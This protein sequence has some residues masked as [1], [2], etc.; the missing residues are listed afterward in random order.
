MR[1]A[2]T[3]QSP[4]WIAPSTP[5]LC[6]A[7]GVAWPG[8]WRRLWPGS[9]HLASPTHILQPLALAQP[10]VPRLLPD[11]CLL[12][13]RNP[14]GTDPDLPTVCGMTCFLGKSGHRHTAWHTQEQ[15]HWYTGSHSC[16]DTGRTL[17]GAVSA[18]AGFSHPGTAPSLLSSPPWSPRLLPSWPRALLHVH[19]H[20]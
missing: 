6:R 7:L 11:L 20:K 17:D 3:H 5:A 18:Q 2:P 1:W 15:A 13:L 14:T 19:E 16:Q 9:W 8:W 4:T 12:R 10:Q